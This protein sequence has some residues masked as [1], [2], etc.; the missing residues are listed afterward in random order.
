M[1]RKGRKSQSRR[2]IA[3]PQ[4]AHPSRPP[5][6]NSRP[7]RCGS[8]PQSRDP[9][10]GA[11]SLPPSISACVSMP[12]QNPFLFLWQKKK[13]FL[14]AKEKEALWLYRGV[15]GKDTAAYVFTLTVWTSPGRYG[16]CGR[17]RETPWSYLPAAWFV[18]QTGGECVTPL[19]GRRYG[20]IRRKCFA[21]GPRVPL[22]RRRS[23]P[24]APT[25]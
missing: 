11:P 6:G 5:S 23:R 16:L 22:L 19:N 21:V 18:D 3:S 9:G 20:L 12:F 15:K 13:R 4:A 24:P 14:N 10:F 17:N 2:G 25:A 1:T 8:S 7:L